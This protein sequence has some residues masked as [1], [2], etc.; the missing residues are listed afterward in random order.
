MLGRTLRAQLKESTLVGSPERMPERGRQPTAAAL[1]GRDS[2]AGA[3]TARGSLATGGT[4]AVKARAPVAVRTNPDSSHARGWGKVAA[5]HSGGAQ[6]G[7]GSSAGGGEVRRGLPMQGA[8]R[9]AGGGG[10]G[11]TTKGSSVGGGEAQRS[12]PGERQRTACW[13]GE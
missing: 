3:A 8:E 11:N 2:L 10:G 9:Q 7:W 5:G 6:K 4:L 13:Q 1:G 12:L